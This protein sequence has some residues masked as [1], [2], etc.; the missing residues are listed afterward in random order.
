MILDPQLYALFLT[1]ALLLILAPG[2]D[3]MFVLGAG[4][5]NGARAGL[6]ACAGVMTGLLVH[7]SLALIGVS[8]LLAASPLAFDLL[9]WAGAAYL[10]WIGIPLVVRAWRNRQAPVA[11]GPM[12]S[13]TRVYWQGLTTNLLNPKVAIFYVAFRA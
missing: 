4:L 10:I 6:L 1:A 12:P 3:T 8:A 11:A 9:R 5:G 7:L 2:P 13:A